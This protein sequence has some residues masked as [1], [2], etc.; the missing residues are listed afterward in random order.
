VSLIAVLPT[1]DEKYALF[2]L[3]FTVVVPF[4]L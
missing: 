2:E 3:P 4:G 1:D